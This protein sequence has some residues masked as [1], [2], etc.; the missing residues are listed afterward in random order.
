MTS[1]SMTILTP[2]E[3]EKIGNDWILRSREVPFEQNSF[4]VVLTTCFPKTPISTYYREHILT[5]LQV[6]IYSRKSI[7]M[8]PSRLPIISVSGFVE[9]TGRLPTARDIVEFQYADDRFIKYSTGVYS[10]LNMRF[11]HY[12]TIIS[13]VRIH[14]VKLQEDR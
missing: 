5:L 2:E 8:P 9:Q 6:G 13:H 11:E 1:D 10:Y 4:Q 7:I 3:M 14:I 12:P